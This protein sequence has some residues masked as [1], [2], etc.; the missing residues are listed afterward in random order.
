MVEE[1]GDEIENTEKGEGGKFR[2]ED[3]RVTAMGGR[4]GNCR[5]GEDR[6]RRWLELREN[7]GMG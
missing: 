6:R 2:G 3:W 4:R 7:Y 5:E 1:F